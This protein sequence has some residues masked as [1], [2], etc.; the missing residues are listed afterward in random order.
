MIYTF[1]LFGLVLIAALGFANF[2]VGLFD[3]SRLFV[4]CLAFQY[5][6]L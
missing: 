5:I 2:S 1:K 6:V 4:L 3:R